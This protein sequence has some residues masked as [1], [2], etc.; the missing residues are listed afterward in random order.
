LESNT[1]A[2]FGRAVQ[3]SPQQAVFL[4][5]LVDKYPGAA[6]NSHLAARV[7]GAACGPENERDNIRVTISQARRKIA[8]LGVRIECRSKIGYRLVLDEMPAVR[9]VA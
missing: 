5:I 4:R 1:V 9:E 8:P 7:W 3:L 6:N 2:R